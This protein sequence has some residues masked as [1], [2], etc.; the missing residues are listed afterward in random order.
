MVT[1]HQL[2]KKRMRALLVAPNVSRYMGGE[3]LKALNIMQG[4]SNLGVEVIQ[5]THARVRKEL[6]SLPNT[7]S[8]HYI[9]DDHVFLALNRLKL[10]WLLSFWES[11]CLHTSAK[12]LAKIYECDIIHFTSPISPTLPY[13]P[14]ENFPVVIGPLNGN[15]L[16]P[17]KLIGRERLIKK[18]GSLILAPFQIVSGSL[19]RGKRKASLLVSGGKRTIDALKLGGCKECQII[20]TLDSGVEDEI[21]AKDRLCQI[22]INHNFVF[23]GRLIK[24]KG[25]DLAIRALPDAPKAIFHIVGDGDERGA[26]EE[27]AVRLGVS[28]RV[29]FHGWI[30]SRDELVRLF[31]IMR[32]FIFPSLAEANGIAVQ[33]A[34]MA[35]LPVVAVNWGG[36]STLLDF[37]SGVLIEPE[38]EGH[39][40]TELATAMQRLGSEAEIAELI[41]KN[42]RLRAEQLG[43]S[44][45]SLLMQWLNIYQQTIDSHD[46]RGK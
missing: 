27:L 42:A 29:V 11:W 3:A 30:S 5:L 18:L 43:F 46:S 13:F 26:L 34:M 15:L 22:G 38:S 44:W 19:F 28:D 35:G 33:E 8:F 17:P 39:I 7:I 37:D 6:D 4:M 24:L 20:E 14:I 41:S 25:C 10:R 9:E 2:R 21:A 40:V 36:P 16:H 32:A 1:D 45:P 23:V 31:Q 12:K